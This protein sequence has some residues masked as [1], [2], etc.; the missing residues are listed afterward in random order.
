MSSS[1]IDRVWASPL[2]STLG[3]QSAKTSESVAPS[4]VFRLTGSRSVP[5]RRS[6]PNSAADPEMLFLPQR[7]GAAR[8]AVVFPELPE[9]R[10]KACNAILSIG[11]VAQQALRRYLGNPRLTGSEPGAVRFAFPEDI[12]EPA[13]HARGEASRQVPPFGK[14]WQGG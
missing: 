11:N 10:R 12:P 14:G 8:L 3:G 4:R 13:A 6:F 9:V 1:Q 7:S 5:V 2:F